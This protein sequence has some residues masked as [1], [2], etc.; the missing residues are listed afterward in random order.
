MMFPILIWT[1]VDCLS[2][3]MPTLYL[4]NHSPIPGLL[5]GINVEND[6]LIGLESLLGSL[7]PN[8]NSNAFFM[9][10]SFK[11]FQLAQGA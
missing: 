2:D 4:L 8:N 9:L 10:Y 7:I 1:L 3:N 6:G 5:I 11:R